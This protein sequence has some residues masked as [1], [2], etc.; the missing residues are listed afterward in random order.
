MLL[1][2]DWLFRVGNWSN[3]ITEMA[4]TVA[5]AL[6]TDSCTGKGSIDLN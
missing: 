5:V 4:P 6:A 2:L 1:F 3:I